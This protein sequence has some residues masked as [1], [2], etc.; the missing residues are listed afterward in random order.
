MGPAIAREARQKISQLG[1]VADADVQLVWDP[2]WSSERITDEWKKK[3]GM[4]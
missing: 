4:G 1:G 3:L 2:P